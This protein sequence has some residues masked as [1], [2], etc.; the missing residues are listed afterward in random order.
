M[1]VV[2]CKYRAEV[3]HGDLWRR[4]LD[5]W[6]GEIHIGSGRKG[7]GSGIQASYFLRVAH[8]IVSLQKVWGVMQSLAKV[9]VHIIPLYGIRVR[10]WSATSAG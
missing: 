1:L 10:F 5:T 3:L 8:S 9:W 6:K 4:S 2:L 7:V